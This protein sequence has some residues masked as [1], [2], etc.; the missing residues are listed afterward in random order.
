MLPAGGD[1]PPAVRCPNPARQSLSGPS[2]YVCVPAEIGDSVR[3]DPI[4]PVHRQ[5]ALLQPATGHGDN[6]SHPPLRVLVVD[7]TV[8]YRKIVGDVLAEMPG[9]EVV[10][11]A[12]NGRIALQKVEQLR[13][14]LLT[15]DL[16]MPEIDGIGVLRQLRSVGA[17]V[18]SSFN[19]NAASAT[20]DALN[21]GA[22]D[23]VVKPAETTF[24]N[25][26]ETLRK[27]LCPKV[28]AFA[29][30]LRP[31][32]AAPAVTSSGRP[33]AQHSAARTPWPSRHRR[34][35][36]I[37]ALG[38]STGG[39]EALDRML[40]R[41]PVDLGVPLV[42]VQHMPPIFTKSLAQSLD[43]K[44]ALRVCEAQ[45]GQPV[46]SGIL[47]APGGRQMKID[48]DDAGAAVVQITDDP[49][50]NSCRPSVDYLFRSVAEIYGSSALGVI[51]TGMGSDGLVGCRR[52]KQL[53]ATILLQDESS[54]IVYGMPRGPAEE[55][56]G[57]H[58]VPLDQ[59]AG[60]IVQCVRRE[61]ALC[62]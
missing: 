38:I 62:N 24:E 20:V 23:F 10:G 9:V 41:L 5:S 14:D 6:V 16:E 44:C 18:L 31:P 34:R 4:S 28:E 51:M 57:D 39:P 60:R 3:A 49:P 53:D 50:E 30:R 54:C 61:V 12:A 8:T 29:R 33:S 1:P 26:Y 55:G 32:A 45:D 13:P 59:I 7:D 48:R 19:A 25:S 47:I 2:I 56:L 40:P 58:I 22:F 36:E 37:V 46:A 52:L 21:A 15:L 27:N 42:I 35:V 43:R 11:V 17:I